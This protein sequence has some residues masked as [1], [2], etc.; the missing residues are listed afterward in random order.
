MLREVE[1]EK[2]MPLLKEFCEEGQKVFDKR[3]QREKENEESLYN[4]D[5]AA[6]WIVT[7]FKV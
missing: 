5:G 4:T 7:Y 2:L 6:E 3:L 1:Q